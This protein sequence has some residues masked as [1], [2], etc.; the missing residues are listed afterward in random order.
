MTEFKEPTMRLKGE[1]GEY[2]V[3]PRNGVLYRH[4]GE[5]AIYDNIFMVSNVRD[6]GSREGHP[7]FL[8]GFVDETRMAQ[9]TAFMFNNGY[10]CHI[11]QVL[12]MDDFVRV[13]EKMVALQAGDI[14]DTI[15]DDWMD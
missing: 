6:D 7:I 4:L 15:P 10:E 14:G 9:I 5:R 3:T 11:N 2:E 8:K 12:V 1:D 13:Y